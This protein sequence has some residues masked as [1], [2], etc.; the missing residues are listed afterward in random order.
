MRLVWSSLLKLVRRPATRRMFILL[1]SFLV[2]IY[3]A[4]GASSRTTPDASS[5]GTIT[6]MLTFPDAHASLAAM[7]LIFAGITG[8]A[9]AGAVAGSEWTWGTFRVAIT[10]GG[11]RARYVGTLFVAIAL[12]AF[13]AWIVLYALGV[14]LI[15]VAG[16]LGGTPSGNPLDAAFLGRLAILVAG[17]GWAVLMEVAIGFS[18]AFV[19]RSQVAGIGAVAGLFFAERFGELFLSTDVLRFAPITAATTIVTNAGKAGVDGGLALPLAV[20]TVYLLLAIGLAAIVARRS[21]VA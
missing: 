6:T 7:L 20:T 5:G 4:L 17:G 15:L 16:S 9:Y 1:A 14:G 21:D 19:A 8:A 3:L 2:L 10:R 18:V 11:S 12:L 13:A